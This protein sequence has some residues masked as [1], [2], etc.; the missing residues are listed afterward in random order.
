[1]SE[2]SVSECLSTNVYDAVDNTVSTPKNSE[3]VVYSTDIKPQES[4]GSK[5]STINDSDINAQNQ[6]D[7]EE[8]ETLL[9]EAKALLK[10]KNLSEAQENAI[11]D[12]VNKAV[13]LRIYG[14]N[15][16]PL[17]NSEMKIYTLVQQKINGK[18]DEQ[19]YKN[20]YK[21]LSKSEKTIYQR[22]SA[23]VDNNKGHYISNSMMKYVVK[24]N[25]GDFDSGVKETD[26]LSVELDTT[27]S[28]A[29]TCKKFLYMFLTVLA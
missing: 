17:S 26:N 16:T 9:D 24:K 4:V 11:I 23:F 29:N 14:I 20:M 2:L 6:S 13:K 3:I 1:M 5:K 27:V 8:I 15:H 25:C 10:N 18:Q 22:V 21:T 12:K 19:Q 7:N 28:S